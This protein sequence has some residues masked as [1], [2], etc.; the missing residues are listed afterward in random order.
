MKATLDIRNFTRSNPAP[1]IP[2]K[3]IAEAALPGWEISLVFAGERRAQSLNI[4]LRK[5]DYIPNVLSY[6]TTS[7]VTRDAQRSGEIIICPAVAKRQASSYDMSYRQFMAY[8][9]IHGLLHL[10]G[11]PH[12]ATMER[13]ERAMMS[14]FGLHASSSLTSSH[15]NGTTHRNR[16]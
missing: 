14:R 13:Y 12:G 1:G 5:K 6:E 2:F 7:T 8:L 9:F 11:H 3:K 16:H 4:A 10:K 15:S